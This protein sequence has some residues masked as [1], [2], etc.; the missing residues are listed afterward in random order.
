M[1]ANELRSGITR[2]GDRLNGTL[3]ITLALTGRQN[4]NRFVDFCQELEAL[5]PGLTVV[6]K[7]DKEKILP[8]IMITDNLIYSAI[9]Q[10]RAIAPFLETLALVNGPLPHLPETL[11]KSLSCIDIPTRLTLYTAVHCPHCPGMVRAMTPLAAACKNIILTVI[12]GTLF[13]EAAASDRVMSVP[14]L[15]LNQE[16]RW[17]GNAPPA[18]VVEMIINQD[19]SML[20]IPSL[21]TILEDGRASWIA[22]KMM[23]ANAVFPSFI[24]LLLHPTW[25]VR[26]G[27]MVVLEEMAE[28]TPDLAARIAP[29]LWKAFGEAD[30]TVKGDILYALGEVGDQ[31][32]GTRI[33]ALIPTLENKDLREAALDALAALASRS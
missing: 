3:K 7:M 32:M 19:P 31:S 5:L 33:K 27:A 25:S 13:P 6:R 22:A 11:Q 8:G 17:T 2:L 18:E 15:I 23:G 1:E 12:D 16:M 20:S 26:L 30:T 21:Q 29:H 9:P 14:C 24:G 10:A 4:D 28:T